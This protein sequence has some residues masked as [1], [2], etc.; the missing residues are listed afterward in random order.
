[1]NIRI[2]IPEN[3]NSIL[4]TRAADCGKD[5]ESYVVNSICEQLDVPNSV[6]SPATRPSEPYPV[7]FQVFLS[8]I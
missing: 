8:Y 1:M 7:T 2:H 5:I 4:T 3:L 6:A